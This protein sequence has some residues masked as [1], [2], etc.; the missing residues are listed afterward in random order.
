MTTSKP[1]NSAWTDMVP[2]GDTALAATLD[3]TDR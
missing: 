3:H 1:T 2:I